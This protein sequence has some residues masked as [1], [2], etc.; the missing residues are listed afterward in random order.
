M[1]TLKHE[2]TAY[3]RGKTHC[4]RNKDTELTDE[5]SR[6]E[7]RQESPQLARSDSIPSRQALPVNLEEQIAR[8]EGKLPRWSVQ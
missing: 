1:A 8:L 7:A 6:S 2:K 3:T 5:R 4:F